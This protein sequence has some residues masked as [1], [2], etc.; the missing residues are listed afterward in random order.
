MRRWSASSA[1]GVTFA[2]QATQRVIVEALLRPPLRVE[3][4]LRLCVF[5]ARPDEPTG[6][7]IVIHLGGAHLSAIEP[8]AYT[9]GEVP[10]VA[11]LPTLFMPPLSAHEGLI[12]GVPEGDADG[13]PACILGGDLLRPAPLTLNELPLRTTAEPRAHLAPWAILDFHPCAAMAGVADQETAHVKRSVTDQTPKGVIATVAPRDP[14]HGQRP[15]D[16]R[17]RAIAP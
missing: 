5:T 9:A 2:D 4:E 12:S 6:L 8:D 11:V 17:P 15:A 14:R 10:P 1:P 16:H 13:A 7:V 3:H